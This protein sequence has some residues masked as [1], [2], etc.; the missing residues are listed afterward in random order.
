[1]QLS[2]LGVAAEILPIF[3]LHGIPYQVPSGCFDYIAV[4]TDKPLFDA[5]LFSLQRRARGGRL[6]C[7]KLAPAMEAQVNALVKHGW[8]NLIL[9]EVRLALMHAFMRDRLADAVI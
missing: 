4:D 5:M 6:G 3:G 8:G 7:L 9:S 1:M 2:K